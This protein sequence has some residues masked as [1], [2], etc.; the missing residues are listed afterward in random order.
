MKN[1]FTAFLI[2]LIFAGF[3][4]FVYSKKSTNLV[5]DILTPTT[6][7]VDLNSNRIFDDG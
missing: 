4:A 6:I 1:Y 3:V 5:L 2:F 7:Q